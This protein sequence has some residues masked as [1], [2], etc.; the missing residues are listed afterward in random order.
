M[1]LRP[2]KFSSLLAIVFSF[3]DFLYLYVFKNFAYTQ[4]FQTV[5][6][7]VVFCLWTLF[8]SSPVSSDV[9]RRRRKIHF[10]LGRTWWAPGM[11]YVNVL[12][13]FNKC[14]LSLLFTGDFTLKTLCLFGRKR[15]IKLSMCDC[16][17]ENRS[18][19]TSCGIC[20]RF[21]CYFYSTEGSW[22]ILF[23]Y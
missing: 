20:T 10:S 1:L 5:F 21:T 11:N 22:I 19:Q 6:S 8:V 7:V 12:I 9:V 4:T 23:S 15:C 16:F 13:V 2:L 17:Y 3:I 18:N 14:Q